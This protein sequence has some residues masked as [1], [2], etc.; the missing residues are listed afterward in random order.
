VYTAAQMAEAPGIRRKDPVLRELPEFVDAD[1]EADV[2][3][4]QNSLKVAANATGLPQ[5]DGQVWQAARRI[6][7]DRAT[8][9]D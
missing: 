2:T 8:Y 6:F 3:R 1:N 7:H 4:W 5:D 9:A